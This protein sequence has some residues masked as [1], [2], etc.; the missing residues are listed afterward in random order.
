MV[1]NRISDHH[2]VK[3]FH[4]YRNNCHHPPNNS[5]CL[6]SKPITEYLK[7]PIT[8][9]ADMTQRS[10]H[11][12]IV[13][14]ARDERIG[15]DHFFAMFWHTVN[16]GWG[17]GVDL[18]KMSRQHSSVAWSACAVYILGCLLLLYN[19]RATCVSHFRKWR[20]STLAKSLNRTELLNVIT[21]FGRAVVTFFSIFFLP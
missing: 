17:G 19:T 14:S 4:S 11:C 8:E 10:P 21:R 9:I 2:Y 20:H 6:Q 3:G 13:T 12:A 5:W 15:R 18:L 16:E 7:Y 1:S